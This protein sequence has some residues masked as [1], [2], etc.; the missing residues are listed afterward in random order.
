MA[1]IRSPTR[2]WG[3]HRQLEGND[4]TF[5]NVTTTF[6]RRRGATA[7][8]LA[9]L[10]S[11]AALVPC[12]TA[13]ASGGSSHHRSHS[14]SGSGGHGSPAP[15]PGGARNL[16][17]SADGTLNTPVGVYSD[18]S[19]ATAVPTGMAAVDTCVRGRTYFVGHNQGVFTP[20]MHMVVGSIVT[21]Y[22]ARGAVHRYRVVAVRDTPGGGARPLTTT[23]HRVA[24][25][26]QTCAVAD[27]SVDRILDAVAA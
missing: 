3:G 8:I 13:M 12:V 15:A 11:A 5:V 27:G 17:T 16:L 23:T 25:Q 9:A 1:S 6:A 18:C 14:G 19:G 2:R 20:L 21:W 7:G 24:A 4:M 22:D 10:V 26:F